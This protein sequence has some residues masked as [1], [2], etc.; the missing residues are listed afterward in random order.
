MMLKPSTLRQIWLVLDQAQIHLLLERS[1]AELSRWIQEQLEA[2]I[3]IPESELKATHHYIQSRVPYSAPE[4]GQ[5]TPPKPK[6]KFELEK[7]ETANNSQGEVLKIGDLIQVKDL[8][9]HGDLRTH[10]EAISTQQRQ[11]CITY[12]EQSARLRKV[13]GYI[14]DI[15]GVNG[16]DWCKLDNGQLICLELIAAFES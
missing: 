13:C 11:C 7:L 15:Y 2:Q 9:S 10:L 6:P 3:F 5:S 4:N 14:V 12:R 8:K 1:D 16:A